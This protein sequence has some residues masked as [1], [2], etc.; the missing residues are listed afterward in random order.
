LAHRFAAVSGALHKTLQFYPSP[1]RCSPIFASSEI[2][3]ISTARPIR[4]TPLSGPQLIT[5]L[6]TSDRR[7]LFKSIRLRKSPRRYDNTYLP[8]IRF[9]FAP[10]LPRMRPISARIRA[11]FAE[12][13]PRRLSRLGWQQ[14]KCATRNSRPAPRWS[15]TRRF[16]NQPHCKERRSTTGHAPRTPGSQQT[17]KSAD[18]DWQTKQA[19]RDDTNHPID[20]SP[21]AAPIAGI[22]LTFVH[23]RQVLGRSLFGWHG[24]CTHP[25]L[26]WSSA[27]RLLAESVGN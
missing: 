15:S 4:R 5:L 7:N 20:A 27:V 22:I 6:R 9:S 1:P 3:P 26:P 17:P 21:L 13:L 2:A 14:Q 19:S 24:V 12:Y 18:R 23:L 25:C 16:G 10:Y 8:N 11:L